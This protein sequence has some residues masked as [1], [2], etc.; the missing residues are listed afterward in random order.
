MNNLSEPSINLVEISAEAAKLVLEIL[1][2]QD[3]DVVAVVE[4]LDGVGRGLD[5]NI[6]WKNNLKP[7]K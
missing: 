4:E 2:A 3:L 5:L 1:A 7:H 6:A